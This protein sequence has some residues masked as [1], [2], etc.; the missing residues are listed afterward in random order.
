MDSTRLAEMDRQR[1]LHVF[2]KDD[3]HLQ[4]RRQ[5]LIESTA[6]AEGNHKQKSRAGA[7]ISEEEETNGEPDVNQV[8]VSDHVLLHISRNDQ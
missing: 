1:L 7:D 6:G 3:E 4:E 2:H 8:F 5:K